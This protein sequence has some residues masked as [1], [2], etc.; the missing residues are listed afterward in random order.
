[1]RFQK[2]AFWT[3]DLRPHY[4][5]DA[6]STVHTKTFENDN[7]ARC[8]VMM[9]SMRMLQTHPPVIFFMQLLFSFFALPTEHTD[10][11]FMRFRFDSPSIT[12]SNRC[13]RAA[14]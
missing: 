5:F 10:T 14:H 13:K 1:M 8:D 6:L 11:M 7:I 3:I 12:L 9:N 4:R 2:Y